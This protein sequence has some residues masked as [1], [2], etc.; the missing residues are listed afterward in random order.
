MFSTCAFLLVRAYYGKLAKY[1]FEN[2]STSH[3]GAIYLLAQFGYKNIL[4]GFVHSFIG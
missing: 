2:A 3:Y 1:L 4:L